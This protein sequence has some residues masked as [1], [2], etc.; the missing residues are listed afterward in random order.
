[1]VFA[2][3]CFLLTTEERRLTSASLCIVLLQQQGLWNKICFIGSSFITSTRNIPKEWHLHC[4]SGLKISLRRGVW[5]W[6]FPQ[7]WA[8]WSSCESGAAR[9]TPAWRDG[10]PQSEPSEA[11]SPCC[12]W[13]RQGGELG[14]VSSLKDQMDQ[15]Q[16]LPFLEPCRQI[17]KD[18]LV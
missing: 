13:E 5:I 2:P 16:M 9:G 4:S 1:M 3:L 17:L 8:L 12:T 6:T 14:H 10:T 11:F 18:S 7:H 15:V